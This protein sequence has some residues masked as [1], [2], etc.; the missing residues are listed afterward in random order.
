MSD[1]H[2]AVNEGDLAAVRSLIASRVDVNARDSQG[3]TPLHRAIKLGHDDITLELSH[4]GADPT[5]RLFSV[6][7]DVDDAG[8]NALHLAAFNGRTAVVR[9]IIDRGGVDVSSWGSV[10]VDGKLFHA[11]ALIFALTGTDVYKLYPRFFYADITLALLDAGAE[12]NVEIGVS[13]T[14]LHFCS[15]LNEGVGTKEERLA[16][17]RALL[18]KGADVDAFMEIEELL[19]MQPLHNAIYTGFY[20]AAELLIHAGAPVN[21]VPEL[22]TAPP[23]FGPSRRKVGDL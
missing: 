4:S 6:P 17:M 19:N 14:P 21:I 9:S 22:A 16:A 5:L 11:P 10:K 2:S 1:L 18:E 12:P 7:D 20:E 13:V 3:R 8:M 15:L 23:L